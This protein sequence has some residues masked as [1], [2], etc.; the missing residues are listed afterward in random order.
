MKVEEIVKLLANNGMIVIPDR[1]GNMFTQETDDYKE[2]IVKLVKDINK[3]ITMGIFFTNDLEPKYYEVYSS[4]VNANDE[5]YTVSE[6]NDYIKYLKN[7]IKV[8]NE[9]KK[10]L[11]K[12]FE[13]YTIIDL[14]SLTEKEYNDVLDI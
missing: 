7:V 9:R 4:Y 1:K 2:M 6:I 11:K 10:I 3:E 8:I 12:A 13:E 14:D 5:I